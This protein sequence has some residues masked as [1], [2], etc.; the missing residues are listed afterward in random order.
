MIFVHHYV[1]FETLAALWLNFGE[2]VGFFTCCVWLVP[3]EYFVSLSAEDYDLGSGG[4]GSS[5]TDAGMS[6]SRGQKWGVLSILNYLS[7]KKEFILPTRR[8][9]KSF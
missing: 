5:G 6:R 2:L 1:A 4:G 3:F 8:G 7:E 9:S